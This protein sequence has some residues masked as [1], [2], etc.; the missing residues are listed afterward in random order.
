MG[1]K[2]TMSV[3]LGASNHT[4]HPRGDLDLYTTDR[5]DFKRFL[6][7][8]SEDALISYISQDVLEPCAGLNDLTEV[9]QEYGFRVRATDIVDRN[10][11]G[12]EIKNFLTD[13]FGEV[14]SIITNPPYALAESM[15]RRGIEIVNNDGWVW[16]L[17][18]IQFLESQARYRLFKEFSPKYVYVY[19][20]RAN[21][22]RDGDTSLGGGAVCYAFFGWVKGYIGETIV[23]WI[24]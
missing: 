5:N 9:L 21:C 19:S 15:V 3:T 16:M 1:N 12:V 24:P 22:Y 18:R 11:L 2:K 23:R 6:N 4:D 8:L 7:Q 13:D 10:N 17:L 14:K 20:K